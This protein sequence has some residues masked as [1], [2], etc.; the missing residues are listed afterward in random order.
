MI[1]LFQRRRIP[2]LHDLAHATEWETYNL[3]SLVHLFWS[4]SVLYNWCNTL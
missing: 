2:D 3:R 1:Q 4:E